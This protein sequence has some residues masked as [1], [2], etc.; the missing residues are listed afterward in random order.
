MRTIIWIMIRLIGSLTSIVI[1]DSL[2]NL[3]KE[4]R[5]NEFFPEIQMFKIWKSYFIEIK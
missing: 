5:K 3:G 1:S 4:R 2:T